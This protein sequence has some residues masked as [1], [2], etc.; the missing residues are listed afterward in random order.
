MTPTAFAAVR[1]D[2]GRILLVRGGDSGDWELPRGRGGTRGNEE[3]SVGLRPGA[4]SIIGARGGPASR[5]VLEHG[6]TLT[7]VEAAARRTDARQSW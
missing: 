5:E 4:A 2:H 7:E 3:Q 1:D 6:G